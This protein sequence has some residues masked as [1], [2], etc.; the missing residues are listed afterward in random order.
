MNFCCAHC[1]F[2]HSEGI[3]IVCVVC[4]V[5]IVV[6]VIQKESLFIVLMSPHTIE[7]PCE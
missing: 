6:F 2:C 1:C 4:V 5:L 7:I 3:S